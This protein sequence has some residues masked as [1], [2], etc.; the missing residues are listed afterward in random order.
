ML[1]ILASIFLLAWLG[2]PPGS[3]WHFFVAHIAGPLGIVLIVIGRLALRPKRQ[4]EE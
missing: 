2:S 1:Y 3:T 4:L